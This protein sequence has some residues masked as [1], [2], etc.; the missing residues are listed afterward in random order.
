MLGVVSFATMLLW[1]ALLPEIFGIPEINFWQALGILVLSKILFGSFFPHQ[2]SGMEQHILQKRNLRNKW[3]NMSKEEK[4][5]FH[6]RMHNRF[7]QMSD[8]II[9]IADDI[10]NHSKQDDTNQN[11]G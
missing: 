8:E 11:I 5:S 9:D 7:H 10:Q 2:R 1:N 6:N 4:E 3:H